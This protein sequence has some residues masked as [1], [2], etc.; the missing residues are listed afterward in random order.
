ML[1]KI[2]TQL[3]QDQAP[4]ADLLFLRPS[5]C[6]WSPILNVNWKLQLKHVWTLLG[7]VVLTPATLWTS[8]YK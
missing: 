8:L 1:D 7:A 3:P 4:V 2:T 6:S 5:T